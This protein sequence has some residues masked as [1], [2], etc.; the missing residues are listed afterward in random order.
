MAAKKPISVTLGADNLVWLR[1]QARASGVRSVSELL[2]RLV[3]DARTSGSQPA[4]SVVG[5]VDIDPADLGLEQADAAI[6]AMF[7]RSLSRPSRVK[8]SS[9]EYGSSERTR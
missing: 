8:E 3:T 7:Y 9:P 4:R 1:G 2:D 5:T 6:R